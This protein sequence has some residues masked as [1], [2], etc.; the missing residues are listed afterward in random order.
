GLGAESACAAIGAA[1]SIQREEVVLAA[2]DGLLFG[3]VGMALVGCVGLGAIEAERVGSAGAV[4][5]IQV[6][7][8][9]EQC[10]VRQKIVDVPLRILGGLENGLTFGI[11]GIRIGAEV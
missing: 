9:L 11:Q 3:R 10:R 6:G 2:I 4:S 8:V 7:I 1:T 5:R